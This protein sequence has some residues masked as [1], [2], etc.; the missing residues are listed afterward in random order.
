M[1]YCMVSN[2]VCSSLNKLM[3]KFW[4]TQV[5]DRRRIC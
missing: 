1:S 4:W 2:T 5:A 3:V